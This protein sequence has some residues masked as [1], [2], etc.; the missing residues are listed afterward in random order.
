MFN[1]FNMGVGIIL[2]VAKEDCDKAWLSERAGRACLQF[3]G[4]EFGEGEGVELC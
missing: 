1:T 2:T 4:A 3:L